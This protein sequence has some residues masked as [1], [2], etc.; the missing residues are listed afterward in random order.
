M[1]IASNL[2][3]NFRKLSADQPKLLLHICCAP[4]GAYISRDILA[5]EFAVTW[6]FYNPNL[7]CREEYD[8]RLA[9][10]RFVAEKYQFPLVVAP[11][12]HEDWLE[13]VRGRE[14][15][16]E[17]GWRCAVCYADRLQAA[18]AFAAEQGFN[19]FSTS[20]LVSPYKDTDT[21]RRLAAQSA[22]ASGVAFLDRDFQADDG[23][24]RSQELAKELGVYRQKFCG[25]E[26]SF[27]QSAL[28]TAGALR[29]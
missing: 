29:K 13:K 23:Y 28:N 4:C 18:A 22:A 11:Y 15:D 16:P 27:S 25:C 10:V 24:R 8:R 12:E 26:Y 17:R 19:Y 20:L 7:C 9:A 2:K 1:R 21:I 6:Y 5:P 3:K 14:D